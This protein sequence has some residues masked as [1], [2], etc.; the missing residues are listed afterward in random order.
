MKPLFVLT[1]FTCLGTLFHGSV[2]RTVKQFFLSSSLPWRLLTFSGSLGLLV[3]LVPFEAGSNHS[4]PSMSVFHRGKG[5]APGPCQPCAQCCGA[6]P[7]L[8]GSGSGYR[9]RLRITKIVLTK[10][11][12]KK[13]S[14]E[15]QH[16][17]FAFLK[18]YPFSLSICV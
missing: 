4:S 5:C 3:L 12:S 1:R 15:N 7:I 13:C 6:G 18:V 11:L 14:F 10:K 2:T 16:I 17:Y 9:L 8:T